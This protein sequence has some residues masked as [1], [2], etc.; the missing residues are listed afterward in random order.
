LLRLFELSPLAL[1]YDQ[2]GEVFYALDAEWR[3]VVANETALLFAGLAREDV[4][5][6][7][8]WS[9]VSEAHGGPLEAAFHQATETKRVVEVE[10]E[11]SLHRG[12]YVRAIAVPLEDGLS[13]TLR[14]ITEQRASESA[15]SQK[16]VSTEEHLRV[17]AEAAQIGTWEVDPQAGNRYWSP[18][19]RSILGVSEDS[20]AD[21]E[22]FASLIDPRDR[23]RIDDMY[24]RA[25][26]GENGGSYAAEFRIRRADNGLRRWLSARGRVFFDDQGRATRGIGALYDISD[27]KHAE[28]ALKESE[29]RFRLAAEAFEGGV[30]D[31]DLKADRVSRTKRQ[32]AIIGE[33]ETF[34]ATPEAWTSRIHPHERDVFLQARQSVINGEASHFEAEYRIRHRD[35]RWVWVWHRGMAMH[36]SAGELDRI[37]SSM[38][39]VTARKHAEDALRESEA[40]FRHLADSAP[41]FIWLTDDKGELTFVNRHFEYVFERPAELI[42]PAGWRDLIYSDDISNFVGEFVRSLRAKR[43]F[44]SEVRVVNKSG[45]V[46]WLRTDAVRR[47]DDTGHFLGYTGCAVDIT[48]TKMSQQQQTILIHELNHRV[49]NTLATVQSI[50]AQSLRA[51]KKLGEARSA[52][53]S[54]LFALSRAHDVLTQE[55]WQA[56]DLGDIVER[57]V[58]PYGGQGRSRF[59]ISGPDVRLQP[60][61]ALAFAMALQELATNAAKYGALSVD[62]GH[63]NVGWSLETCLDGAQLRFQWHESGGPPV[64]PPSRRGFGSRLIERTLAHDTNGRVEISYAPSGL[65]L[66]VTVPLPHAP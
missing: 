49:K 6:R 47:L 51:D 10:M 11:S 27:R 21:Y 5:G 24:R 54:R 15:H 59:T 20:Q 46:R 2:L 32:L 44:R 53:E 7:S 57:A 62:E 8:Y 19:F 52:F 1:H 16:L 35:G 61:S 23:D 31:Y 42:V 37:I 22:L 34:P 40:R 45:H 48:E 56:A 38:I 41:A 60:Q 39:E 63:V 36:D 55:S 26:G 12:R 3:I 43:P 65:S 4:I 18:Q 13:I 25:Y 64:S 50:A 29:E 30:A 9:V 17:A 33:D 14:D 58:E 66:A 28:G